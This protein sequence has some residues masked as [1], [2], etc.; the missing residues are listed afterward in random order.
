MVGKIKI[1]R[2]RNQQI[3]ESCG[4]QPINE[5]VERRKLDEHVTTRMDAERLIKISRDNIPAGIIS[6]GCPKRRWSDLILDLKRRNR[7]QQK[8]EQE[9]FSQ[10]KIIIIHELSASHL[11]NTSVI[12]ITRVGRG[13][14]SRE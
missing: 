5:R 1:D 6:P 13:S 4:I 11:K 10:K 8:E 9:D 2:I 3:R 12:K 14:S 7:L